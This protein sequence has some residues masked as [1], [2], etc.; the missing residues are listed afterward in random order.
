MELIGL[1]Y[2]LEGMTPVS[3]CNSVTGQRSNKYDCPGDGT[4]GFTFDYPIPSVG[5]GHSTSWFASGFSGVGTIRMYAERDER[6]MVGE[7]YFTL[8]T[9]VTNPDGKVGTLDA[10]RAIGVAMGVVTFAIFLGMLYYFCRHI[11]LRN[12]K[13]RTH[14]LVD[15]LTKDDITTIWKRLDDETRSIQS[16]LS[17]DADSIASSPS[18]Q[19]FRPPAPVS[20][21]AAMSP[22]IT[23]E[24]TE[25]DDEEAKAIGDD[26]EGQSVVDRTPMWIIAPEI[27]PE[28][29]K[30]K[31]RKPASDRSHHLD[32]MAI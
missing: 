20:S 19:N 6:M 22:P 3:L 1:N 24:A 21:Q 11:R 29:S 5:G 27:K 12:K 18:M 13:I 26:A 4:Y 7:C 32:E 25:D 10:A 30:R 8:Q 17:K 31:H 14:K 2:E 23:E 9:Y 16:V 15:H 28:S